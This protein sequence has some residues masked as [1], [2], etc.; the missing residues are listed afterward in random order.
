MWR[1]NFV[2]RLGTHRRRAVKRHT[3]PPTAQRAPLASLEHTF[4]MARPPQFERAE[5]AFVKESVKSLEPRERAQLLVWL[6]LYFNDDGSLYS[7]QI[8][9]RRQRITLDDV[10]YWLVRVP[11]R[12]GPKH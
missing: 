2:N 10:E 7:P 9:R 6:L 4:A 1:L 11:S 12:V 5:P 3:G 8:S